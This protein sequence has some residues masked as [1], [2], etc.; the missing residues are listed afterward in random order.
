M[1][2]AVEPEQ[3]SLWWR[4]GTID[5]SRAG[6]PVVERGDYR[7]EQQQ[8]RQPRQWPMVKFMGTDAFCDQLLH[9]IDSSSSKGV[10]IQQAPP[11]L[12]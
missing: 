9:L 3:E 4:E 8:P 2:D 10:T 1:P 12:A 6:K 5:Q 7:P 11:S